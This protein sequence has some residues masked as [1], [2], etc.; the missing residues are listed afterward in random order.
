MV[1]IL[2]NIIVKY[3]EVNLAVTISCKFSLNSRL[4]EQTLRENG[5][6]MIGLSITGMRG[7]N[8]RKRE[9]E[10]QTGGDICVNK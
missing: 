9:G 3:F 2:T 1:D 10:R 5:S 6:N 7:F 8:G 4:G